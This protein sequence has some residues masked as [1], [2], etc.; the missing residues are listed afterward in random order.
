MINEQLKK[1]NRVPSLNDPNDWSDHNINDDD[2]DDIVLETDS[3]ADSSDKTLRNIRGDTPEFPAL[4]PLNA[5]NT[6][7]DDYDDSEGGDPSHTEPMDY[8]EPRFKRMR[9]FTDEMKKNWNKRPRIS[10]KNKN[11]RN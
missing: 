10:L 2:D 4:Q 3:N 1:K 7:A 11:E 8:E 6:Y 9:D 5:R